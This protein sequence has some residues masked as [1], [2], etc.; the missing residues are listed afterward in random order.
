MDKNILNVNC[1]YI[2]WL[3]VLNNTK[4]TFD[5]KFMKTLRKTKTDLK[6][7]LL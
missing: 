7:A 3:C 4:A 2:I 1:L 5:T 6:K